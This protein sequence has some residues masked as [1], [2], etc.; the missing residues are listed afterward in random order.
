MREVVGR[1]VV[2]EVAVGEIAVADRAGIVEVDTGHVAAHVPEHDA[3]RIT[4]TCRRTACRPGR[5]RSSPAGMRLERRMVAAQV[6]ESSAVG[7]LAVAARAFGDAQQQHD[8]VADTGGAG[9]DRRD[10]LHAGLR[11]RHV[12]GRDRAGWRP[13]RA[14]IGTATHSPGRACVGR[15]AGVDASTLAH[16]LDEPG[17]GLRPREL[18][19]VGVRVVLE[20]RLQLVVVEDRVDRRRELVGDRGSPRAARA[21]RRA[22]PWRA[23]TASR[24]PPSRRRARSSACRS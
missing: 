13:S 21:R 24:R 1:A 12:G 6:D 9:V 17:A 22:P 11:R 14:P 19:R 5:S 2:A 23:G 8:L 20:P 18:V 7:Q 4:P 3:R 10:H 16:D 15:F